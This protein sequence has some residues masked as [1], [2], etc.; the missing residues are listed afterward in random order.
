MY[1]DKTVYEGTWDND[2]IN[3]EGTSIYANGNKYTGEFVNGKISGR[4]Y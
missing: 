1:L 2:K 4:G 3:G